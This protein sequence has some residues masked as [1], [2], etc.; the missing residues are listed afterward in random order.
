MFRSL[1]RLCIASNACGTSSLAA[2]ADCQLQVEFAPAQA[3]VATGL[4]TFTDGAGTQ[5][6][7]L[8]GTGAA[9]PTDIL[10]TAS[11]TFPATPDGQLSAAQ[12]VTITNSGG[13]PLTSIAISASGEFQESS[14][15]VTQL[16]AGAV[17]TIS[18]QFAPT[19][20]G[21]L[22]GTLTIADALRTQ[23]VAMS[24]TGLAPPAFSV[25][26]A[27]LTFTNQQPGVA[28]A[29]QTLT[30]TNS[31]GAPM[32]NVGFQITGAAAANYSISAT[33]CSA[34]LNNGSSCTA[35]IVFTPSATGAIAATLAVSSSTTGVAAVAVPL[36][37]SGQL[38]AALATNPSQI[39][40]PVVAAG[41]SSA[42]QAVTVTNS[43]S[44][45]IGS[46]SLAAG[47]PF[48]VTQNTCTGGLA[49]GA[50]CTASV[51]FQPNAGGSAS[52]ALMVTSSAVAAPATVALS[53]TGFDFAVSVSGPASQTV[54]RG[55]QGDYTLVISP[56][57]SS[58]AFTFS[59]G[60]LPSNAVCSSIPPPNHSA[61]AF[62][63]MWKWKSQRAARLWLAS[64]S[65]RT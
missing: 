40:F 12:A 16:A 35:Q 50:N 44:Y 47:A 38:A 53:G 51:V 17:C 8:S 46:V 15:C 63:A 19:Q 36:N 25:N 54:A 34:V 30:F 5:T 13:V 1:R 49:S 64:R 23:T 52:G 45:A 33:T 59:C 42:A 4:L 28:S 60:T 55:Q 48:N 39:T 6:V 9:A 62:R 32:A 21:A 22:N 11:L 24:G 37:G 41:Q 10:N 56:S 65:R 14:N 61:R 29:P 58:G 26:P 27:S 31:G 57:G 3:G 43:S 7:A 2:S 20:V 18:V